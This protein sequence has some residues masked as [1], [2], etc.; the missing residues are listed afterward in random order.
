MKTILIID[1]HPI[2][3]EGISS[4]LTPKGY[5]VLKATGALQAMEIL[6]HVR[7]VDMIVCDLSLEGGCIGIVSF[8]RKYVVRK[9]CCSRSRLSI[10]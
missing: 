5:K 6:S 7:P 10:S 8:L 9:Y 1:D 3:L 2:V 4:V